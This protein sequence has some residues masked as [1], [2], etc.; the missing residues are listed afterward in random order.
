MDNLTNLI[1]NFETLSEKE[2]LVLI[3]SIMLEENNFPDLCSLLIE[4]FKS[5]TPLEQTYLFT[6]AKNLKGCKYVA[7]SLQYK[8]Y[9]L[10]SDFRNKLLEAIIINNLDKYTHSP[11]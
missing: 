10:P 11:A 7:L 5:T 8:F 2:R 6:L 9:F 3:D 4:N 1:N